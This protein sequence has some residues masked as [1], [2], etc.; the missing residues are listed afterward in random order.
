MKLMKANNSSKNY[1]STI[2]F[3]GLIPPLAQTIQFA[4]RFAYLN[5]KRRETKGKKQKTKP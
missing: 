2:P 3:K 5:Q 1:F 4:S